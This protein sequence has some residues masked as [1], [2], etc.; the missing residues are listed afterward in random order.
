MYLAECP[1]SEY[2]QTHLVACR[3]VF[4]DL[5]HPNNFKP[6]GLIHPLRLNYFNEDIQRCQALGLSMFAELEKASIHFEHLQKK[7]RVSFQKRLGI[8]LQF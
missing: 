6:I 2:A 1:P 4:N 7:R 5:S 3:F 8:V